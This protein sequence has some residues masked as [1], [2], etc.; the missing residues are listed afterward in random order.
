[1]KKIRKILSGILSAAMLFAAAAPASAA[2]N[3]TGF[4]DV[5]AGVWYANAV[6]YARENG[7]MS[8]VGNNAFAPNDTTNLAMLLS[9]LHRDAGTPAATGSVPA[10]VTAGSWY[11]DAATW[12][13]AEGLLQNVNNNFN[14]APLTRED[15][16]TVLWRYAG[17]P[18]V[19][20]GETFADNASISSCSLVAGKQY[21]CRQAGQPVRPEGQR[22]P[23]GICGYPAKLYEHRNRCA[24]AGR[25]GEYAGRVLLRKRYDRRGCRSH[26]GSCER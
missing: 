21:R 12:A 20:G 5:S 15:M 8:G 14:G 23:G 2:V 10:G 19:T 13:N 4:T 7:L 3:D 11:A 25:T 16:V 6:Q 24:T 9:T 26:R 1:M 22:N 17:S 18:A